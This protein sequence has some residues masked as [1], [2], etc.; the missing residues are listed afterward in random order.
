M[1]VI[2][3]YI[4]IFIIIITIIIIIILVIIV[5]IITIIIIIIIIIY[6]YNQGINYVSVYN[7]MRNSMVTF[8]N[9]TNT[10]LFSGYLIYLF[11]FCS[12]INIYLI[13]MIP[14]T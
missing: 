9:D 3:V 11:V 6:I 10:M 1:Y 4:Y 2:Y 12:D 13:I 8:G 14:N 5:I 7:M